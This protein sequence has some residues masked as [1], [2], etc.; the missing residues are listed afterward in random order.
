MLSC[1]DLG[2]DLG[3]YEKGGGGGGG[4]DQL[5]QE[6]QNKYFPNVLLLEKCV[7]CYSPH[8]CFV[9]KAQRLTFFLHSF[10]SKL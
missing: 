6:H 5:Q 4:G 10:L 2:V 3:I 9:S 7:R 1:Y 8:A